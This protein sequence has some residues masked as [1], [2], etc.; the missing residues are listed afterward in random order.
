MGVTVNRRQMLALM[1]ARG[2]RGR[3]PLGGTFLQFWADHLKWDGER[4]ERLFGYLEA[5]RVKE[6]VVQWS[7]Y[8]GIDYGPLVEKVL[9][10]AGGRGMRVRVGLRHESRWWKDVEASPAEALNRLEARAAEIDLRWCAKVGRERAFAGW[11]LPE[12]ID[13]VHWRNGEAAKALVEVVQGVRR[14]VGR[15]AAS[16]FAGGAAGPVE[17]AAFW[18]GLSRRSGL[19]EVLFQ[20]GIGAGKLSLETWPAYAQALERGLGGRLRVVVETFAASSGPGEF[21]AVPAAL[22]R[23]LAQSRVAWRYSRKSP[24]AFSL[25]EYYT[26]EG[27]A[28]A[29]ER[30]REYLACMDRI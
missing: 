28:A 26:P 22:D 21:Q 17:V 5:L 29:G 8:D 27:G 25:P 24:L 23:V 18:R 7:G 14:K 6:L 1:A 16:G 20:D 2:T 12:E 30:Y 19:E 11:Y 13:D 4:W 15:L 3:P 10:M 9:E